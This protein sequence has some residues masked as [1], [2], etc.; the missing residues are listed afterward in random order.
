MT[1]ARTLLLRHARVVATMD[2]AIDAAAEIGMRF[3]ATRGSMSVGESAGGLP[4]DGVVERE[5]AILRDSRRVI[6]S[7][8]DPDGIAARRSVGQSQG[9][10]R[11]E[12][13]GST[14]PQQSKNDVQAARERLLFEIAKSQDKTW[15]VR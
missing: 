10:R 11:P 2:D 12:L 13:N 3:H 6:E 4:P 7:F 5:D 1:A 8:H 14:L 15:P 9:M